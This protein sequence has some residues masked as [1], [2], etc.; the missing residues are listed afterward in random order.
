LATV[1][2]RARNPAKALLDILR[3]D[4]LVLIVAST[5][6]ALATWAARTFVLSTKA[7]WSTVLLQPKGRYGPVQL[8]EGFVYNLTAFVLLGPLYT[9]GFHL[10][11]RSQLKFPVL[12][13]PWHLRF[14]STVN[15][16]VRWSFRYACTFAVAHWLFYWTFRSVIFTAVSIPPSLFISGLSLRPMVYFAM[17][18]LQRVLH[19]FLGALQ[20]VILWESVAHL[21]EAIFTEPT[22]VDGLEGRILDVSTALQCDLDPY[23]QALAYLDLAVIAVRDPS[24]RNELFN[25]HMDE[26]LP[27]WTIIASACLEELDKVADNLERASGLKDKELALKRSAIPF[28]PPPLSE[29]LRP[30]KVLL[31]EERIWNEPRKT[32]ADVVFA[33]L[34]ET[35]AADDK[36]NPRGGAVQAESAVPALLRRGGDDAAPG[37]KKGSGGVPARKPKSPGTMLQEEAL[38]LKN[39]AR[40]RAT[41]LAVRL[42]RAASLV[43]EELE[44]SEA[45][46]EEAFRNLQ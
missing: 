35:D 28:G 41:A 40:D 22:P 38:A 8:N 34:A 36:K 9:V 46:V 26:S 24:A 44:Q 29:R 23:E 42:L 10:A 6:S 31:K 18:D 17:W 4:N 33:S 32:I 19:V 43:D 45:A 30:H 39:W 16:F 12:Q 7:T 5:V 1:A 13:R 3:G 14:M 37:A 11:E 21:L 2:R 15:V 20:V 25:D 27:P